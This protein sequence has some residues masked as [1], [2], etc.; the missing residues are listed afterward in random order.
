MKHGDLH[1][2]LLYSRLGDCPV[3][4]LIVR[5][6]MYRVSNTYK[7]AHINVQTAFNNLMGSGC[8]SSHKCLSAKSYPKVNKDEAYS[9]Q[10]PS[11]PLWLH[12]HS[13]IIFCCVQFY[14]RMDEMISLETHGP[15]WETRRL[16]KTRF[17]HH[18]ETSPSWANVQTHGGGCWYLAR[19][20]LKSRAV[21]PSA[22]LKVNDSSGWTCVTE[23]PSSFFFLS[24]STSRH[25]CWWSSWPT[26]PEGWSTSAARTSSTETSLLATACEHNLRFHFFFLLSRFLRFASDM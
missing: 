24:C 21:A 14:S 18:V 13:E 16:I 11:T 7:Q 2:Y 26:S 20:R 25:K 23:I 6:W 17:L 22:V 3:V 4:R 9:L 8:R 5:Q 1:S 15:R 10:S 12:S 19:F